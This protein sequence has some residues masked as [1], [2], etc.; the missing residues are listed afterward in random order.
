M[1]KVFNALT[2]I[3]FAVL[4]VGT[5]AGVKIYLERDAIIDNIKEQAVDAVTNGL[6]SDFDLG[7]E[8]P[9]EIPT[10]PFSPMGL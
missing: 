8:N 9:V 7:V 2:V 5:A 6:V 4:T 1:Q 10:V 3:G